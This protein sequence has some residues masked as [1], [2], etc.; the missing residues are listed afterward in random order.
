MKRREDKP[1]RNKGTR[2]AIVS[3]RNLYTRAGPGQGV[4]AGAVEIVT[5]LNFAFI[6]TLS[7]FPPSAEKRCEIL[8]SAFAA[9]HFQERP[10]LEIIALS[11]SNGRI[12]EWFVEYFDS[13]D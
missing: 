5:R 12:A 7:F 4:R 8:L 2:A 3:A 10:W 1:R 9:L 13:G 11:T 6:I